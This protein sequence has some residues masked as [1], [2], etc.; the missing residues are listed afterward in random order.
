MESPELLLMGH[1]FLY[2]LDWDFNHDPWS[3]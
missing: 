1:L 2:Y 3:A